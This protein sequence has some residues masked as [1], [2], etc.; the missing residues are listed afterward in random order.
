LLTF[1]GELSP[2][3][4]LNQLSPKGPSYPGFNVIIGNLEE[5]WYYSNRDEKAPRRLFNNEV[6]ELCKG[7]MSRILLLS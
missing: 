2:E 6:T 1:S 4:F 7:L 5:I 3:E